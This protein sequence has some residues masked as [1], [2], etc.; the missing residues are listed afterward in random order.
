[1]SNVEKYKVFAS[2]SAYQIRLASD[3]EIINRAEIVYDAQRLISKNNTLDSGLFGA[4]LMNPICD[5]CYNRVEDCPGHYAVIQLPFPIVRAICLKDFKLLIPIICPICSALLCPNVQNA[6]ELAPENRLDWVRKE[7]DKFTKSGEQ[8]V[9]CPRCNRKISVMKILQLEPTLR[10]G[11]VNN[12]TNQA[13]QVSPIWIQLALQSFNQIDEIGFSRNYHPKNFMTSVIPI[14]PNKLRPKTITSSESTLTSYYRVIIEE[15]CPELTK[16]Y[17]TLSAK[18]SPVIPRGDLANVFNKFYDRLMAYYLLI[19]DMGTEKTR[20]LELQLIEKRDRKHVDVHNSLIGRF[21]DK[22]KSI[23]SKGIIDS[24][25]NISA[26]TVLG[27]AVDSG[28][29]CVNV[30]YHIANKLTMLY[31]VYVQNLKLMKQITAAMSDSNIRNNINIPHVLAIVDGRTNKLTK[32]TIK[33]AL[34]R[35]SLIKPGDRVAISLLNGDLLLQSRFPAV[36]E[37]SW[38]SFQC[39]KDNNSIITIPLSDCKMKMADF[40]GDE[41]QIYALSSHVT[42]I[43]ALLLHSTY[44]QLIA[45]KDGNP[46]IWYSADAPFGL[47]KIVPGAKSYVYHDQLSLPELDVIKTVESYFPQD[48]RYCDSKTCIID[49]KFKDGKTKIDNKE[50]HKYMASIYGARIT[51]EFMDKCIQLAYDLNH[52]YGTTLGFEL[53]IYGDESQQKVKELIDKMFNE[54]KRNEQSNIKHKDFIQLSTIEKA[55]AV[56]KEILLKSS[57]GTNIYELGYA[58]ERQDEYYQTVVLIDHITVEGTRIKP[59]LAEGSRVNCAFPRDSVDPRAYGFVKGGYNSDINPIAHFYECIQQRLAMFV[60]GSGT[61]K[62]GYMSKRLCAAYGNNYVD[63]TGQLINNFKIVSTQYGCC[64]LNPRLYVQQPLIDLFMERDKFVSK[65]SKDKRLIV[66]YDKIHEYIDV[67]ATF[68]NFTTLEAI[69]DSFAA[70]FNYNEYIDNFGE[71]GETKEDDINKFIEKLYS[72]YCP[73][74]YSEQY[75]K[76]N[77]IEHEYYFRTKLKQVKCDNALLNKLYERF[78]WSLVDG[79]DPV[80][81][82]ASIATSEPLT[83]ASLHSIHHASG[84][85]VD[86]NRIV[87][88]MGVDRFEE[89]LGGNKCKNNVVTFKLYDDSREASIAFANEQETFHFNNIWTR[90]ELGICEKIPENVIKLHPK[91]NLADV[92]VNTYF[93]KSIWTVNTISTYKIHIVD[94]INALM[95]NYHEIMFITGVVL[96]STEFMAYIFFKPTV[97][98]SQINS[99]IEDWS[100]ENHRT[101]IH[102]KYLRNCFVSENKNKPGHYIIEANEVSSQVMALQN[103]IFDPRVDPRGCKSSNPEV[104]YKLFGVCE[105]ATRQYEELIYTAINL[106]DTNGVL[107]RHYKV[108][109]DATYTTG[110]P[111]YASRNS[112]RHVREMDTLRL[113][114]FETAKD[115]IQQSLRFGFVQPVSDPVASQVFGELPGIG[116]GAS[117]IQIYSE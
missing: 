2:N 35:A 92:E 71:K 49:G 60:R 61:A 81:M 32:I 72:V 11:I 94:V 23:F 91:V 4:T 5:I 45:Y 67:Y 97:K 20:E 100:F 46:A 22:E 70:G 58:T 84:G 40:D 89:L 107:H 96:N 75:I 95:K 53:R 106:S 105:A 115:M 48:F 1:M 26:R 9:S 38:G 57:I 17:K 114:Q 39:V 51:E 113:V 6:L 78:I 80:G 55:K 82:K 87:K 43:E 108:L 68:T 79:G 117:K 25:V 16:I 83:Q 12:N 34:T 41:A 73:N 27:G 99:I 109:A 24:R 86:E 62:Q 21:K 76:E 66:C 93:V 47:S 31:P 8:V 7:S 19:T 44:Q 103:L 36:R 13:D 28:V 112:L 14:I 30:P 64:G 18:Y 77:L 110:E 69:K 42:D 59:T 101:I 63:F 29:Q 15:I 88:S 116:T 104:F 65:Y 3:E 52:D 98:V 102:G 54:M 111:R 85:G 10:I 50:M 90:L 37:E 74:Q 56:I 33:N